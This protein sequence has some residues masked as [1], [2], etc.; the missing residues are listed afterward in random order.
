MEALNLVSGI[1]VADVAKKGGMGMTEASLEQ[2]LA[3]NPEVILCWNDSQGGCY[4]KLLSDP[5]WAI[6]QGNEGSSGV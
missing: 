1:D 4:S 5:N 3:W 2:V 6:H